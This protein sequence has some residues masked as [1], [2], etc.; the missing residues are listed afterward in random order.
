MIN[1]ILIAVLLALLV[2]VGG[3]REAREEE[4]VSP[5]S[6]RGYDVVDVPRRETQPDAG[7]TDLTDLPGVRETSEVSDLWP[8]D[9]APDLADASADLPLPPDL[10]DLVDDEGALVGDEGGEEAVPSVCTPGETACQD[11]NVLLVCNEMGAEWET[12][13]SCWDEGVGQVCYNGYCANVCDLAT[14][15]ESYLGCEFWAADLD[16]AFVPGGRSGYYDAAGA[17]FSVIVSNPHPQ[18][19]A[20]VEIRDSDGPVLLAGG[21]PLPSAPIPPGEAKIYNL[22]R[23]DV[24][25]TVVDSLAYR[26]KSTIPVSVYQFNPLENVNVFSN[27]ASLILPSGAAG[28]L[29][30]VMTREQSFESLRSFFTVVGIEASTMVT[31][32]VTATTLAGINQLNG[33][34]IKA[35]AP[36]DSIGVKLGPYEVLNIETD[37]IGGDLTGSLI[38]AT[39]PV[40]VFGGSEA[41]NAP[42]T[43]HCVNGVCEWDGATPCAT[44]ADCTTAG[45]NTCC[46]DHL[47]QQL[48]PVDSWGD[49]YLAAKTYPRGQE[50]DVYRVIAAMD[51]TEIQTTPVQAPLLTLNAGEWA[52]FES[53]ADFVIGAN[54]PI[55]VGQFIPAQD[56]P[57]PNLIGVPQAGDAGIGDP[58][59]IL[60]VPTLQFRK[61]YVFVAPNK[62]ELD[63]V[64]IVA[65]ADALVWLDCS[66]VVPE[67]IQEN[68]T[69]VDAFEFQPFGDGQFAAAKFA[70][71]DGVHR[72]YAG[73]PVGVY[74]YGYDQ[75]VSYGY[76]AGLNTGDLGLYDQPGQ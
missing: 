60:L 27:D 69:P 16:N 40:A 46:A 44:S 33:E 70:V 61:N 9:S 13:T 12:L 26:V 6:G 25:G 18:W 30:Y 29:F 49:S 64:T 52:E 65:P 21:V 24:D 37:E 55:M 42:N 3:C 8:A 53:D 2:D 43:N 71:G 74:V 23:R 66:F 45:F 68:C 7:L 51:G 36:G 34:Q 20:A 31:V 67:E 47:E 28:Q 58:A 14:D 38:T 56:A 5:D 32:Q 41:A 73:Q 62:Y 17:Q 11:D 10:V 59:F 72:I 54:H 50:K 63:Y 22:P 35:L 57:D 75:Y 4:M 15:K 19:A 48:F 39:K 76:P 1:R